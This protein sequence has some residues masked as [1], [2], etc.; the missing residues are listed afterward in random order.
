ML[1]NF[2]LILFSFILFHGVVLGLRLG[3]FLKTVFLPIRLSGSFWIN[4]LCGLIIK[5]MNQVN[6]DANLKL[7]S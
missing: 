1:L 3:G 4:V 7:F 5:G 6:H 2:Y